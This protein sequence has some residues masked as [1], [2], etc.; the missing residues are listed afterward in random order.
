VLTLSRIA[1]IT[2]GWERWK[3]FGDRRVFLRGYMVLKLG[4]KEGGRS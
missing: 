4:L 2:K 3:S 1:K